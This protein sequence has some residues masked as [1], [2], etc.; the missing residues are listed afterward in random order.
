MAT[1]V[2]QGFNNRS[3]FSLDNRYLK[4]G[5]EPYA[6]AAEVYSAIPLSYRH[7][8]LTVLIGDFEFHFL[9]GVADSD[10]K[11]KNNAKVVVLNNVDGSF[12]IPAGLLNYAL[13]VRANGIVTAFKLGFTAGAEDIITST[14][15]P[16]NSSQTFN[17]QIFAD[18]N[19]TVYAS[20]IAGS[21]RIVTLTFYLQ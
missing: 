21:T 19:R 20:G 18:S 8:G 10:L 5:F 12:V 11:R 16:S 1:D 4:N 17:T 3:P 6:S 2:N 9:N 14:E 7:P 15:I 13:V